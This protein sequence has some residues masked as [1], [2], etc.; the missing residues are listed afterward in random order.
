MDGPRGGGSRE[1]LQ[2]NLEASRL[3][4]PLETGEGHDRRCTPCGHALVLVHRGADWCGRATDA[5]A[6]EA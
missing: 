2:Y 1:P 6:R 5:L 3:E 4:P